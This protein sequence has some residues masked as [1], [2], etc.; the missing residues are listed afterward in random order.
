MLRNAMVGLALWVAVLAS[1]ARAQEVGPARGALVIVGGGAIGGEIYQRF[2][3]LAGGADAPIV[4]IPTAGT[5]DEEYDG[6]YSGLT[7]FRRAG[8]TNLILLHTRDRNEADSEAF[9]QPIRGA[10]GVFFEGGRQWRLADSY[11]GTKVQD[12]LR[13]LLARGGVV[14]GTSAGATILG[15]YLVRGDTR[16]NEIMMGD[17]EQGFA[18]LKGVAIDQHVLK[19]NRQF[20]LLQVIEARPDL[21]GIA[22]DESTAIVVQGDEFRVLGES[23]ALI[24]DPQSQLATGGPF[25]FLAPGDRFD[26]KTRQAFRPSASEQ[27]VARVV[28]KPTSQK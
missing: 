9:V 14:G 12:E 26:L 23:Y 1:G 24:F 28:R 5:D 25:Y 13:A 16:G 4:V 6:F 18:F 21:L 8:A 11:L 3:E 2:L 15:D 17:H 19:R 27:P 7:A 22:I 20:D 10:G